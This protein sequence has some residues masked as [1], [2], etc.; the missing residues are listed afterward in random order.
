[1]WVA[2]AVVGAAA[3]GGVASNIAGNKAANAAQDAAKTQAASSANALDLEREQFEYQKQLNEPFYNM[4][5][6]AAASYA[7]AITGK[8]QTFTGL[9]GKEQT[10][11]VW[12]PQETEAY[13]WQQRQ[14]EKQT[15][16]SLR[17]MGRYNSTHGMD[18]I[19]KG[20]SNLAADEY[21]KQLG[22]LADLTNVARG[23]ASSLSS[24]SSQFANN[25]GNNIINSGNNQAN[26]TL[27]GGMMQS[28]AINN[29]VQGLYSLA[30][31]GLKYYGNK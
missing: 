15:G 4:G 2:V 18:A 11:G 8:P 21:D 25:A 28:N 17:A 24:M 3:V 26:A 23:G 16:R 7:S 1:M 20:N 5:L 10:A 12:T 19:A 14:M 31:M 6:P 29:G 22:R 13:K 30:N 9:D 27:A